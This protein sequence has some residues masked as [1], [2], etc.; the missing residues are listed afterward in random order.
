M[1][2]FICLPHLLTDGFKLHVEDDENCRDGNEREKLAKLFFHHPTNAS[3][4][5][6]PDS[7]GIRS[8]FCSCS[9]LLIASLRAAESSEIIEDRFFFSSS[10]H[11][12]NA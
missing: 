11:E 10:G 3:R 2:E 6:S 9:G 7:E 8:I 1:N 12:E 5:V 4:N